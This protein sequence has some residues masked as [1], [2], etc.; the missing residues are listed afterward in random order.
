MTL[1]DIIKQKRQKLTRKGDEKYIKEE[2]KSL[3]ELEM[4]SAFILSIF[5]EN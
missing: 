4:C 3:T 5:M 2:R 1:Y